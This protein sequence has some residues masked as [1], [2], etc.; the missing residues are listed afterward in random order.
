MAA[1]ARSRKSWRSSDDVAHPA[2]RAQAMVLMGEISSG[3][4][5]LEGAAGTGHGRHVECSDRQGSPTCPTG[6]GFVTG[7]NGFH[8]GGAVELG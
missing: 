3:R 7:D 4:Q 8:A 5:A 1:T 2:Q 6:E